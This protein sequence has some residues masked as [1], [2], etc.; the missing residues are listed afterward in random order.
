VTINAI[1]YGSDLRVH[2]SSDNSVTLGGSFESITFVNPNVTTTHFVI[3][4]LKDYV[5][6]IRFEGCNLSVI[7]NTDKVITLSGDI[8]YLRY[9]TEKGLIIK[10][11][12]V[13]PCDITIAELEEF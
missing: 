1:I 11:Y 4:S 6:F 5:K 12:V 10:S 9:K 2:L 13:I 8:K 3:N 7:K